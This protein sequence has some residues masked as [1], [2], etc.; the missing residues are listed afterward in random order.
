MFLSII[1]GVMTVLFEPDYILD[2]MEQVKVNPRQM[3]GPNDLDRLK[4]LE[5]L[6]ILN[7]VILPVNKYLCSLICLSFCSFLGQVLLIYKSLNSLCPPS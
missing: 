4:M 6:L 3:R 2:Q 5:P 1:R 7:R